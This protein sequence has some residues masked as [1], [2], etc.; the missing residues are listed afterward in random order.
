MYYLSSRLEC[1]AITN[2]RNCLISNELIDECFKCKRNYHLNE[3]GECVA[4]SVEITNANGSCIDH[5]FYFDSSVNMCVKH[6]LLNTFACE[7]FNPRE[8]GCLECSTGYYLESG[9]CLRIEY[10]HFT[11]GIHNWCYMSEYDYGYIDENGQ[12]KFMDVECHTNSIENRCLNCARYS[13]E[14]FF[15]GSLV[16]EDILNGCANIKKS[17]EIND[18]QEDQMVMKS[19][20]LCDLCQ[21]LHY[22]DE[23]KGICLPLLDIGCDISNG[24]SN[25]CTFCKRTHILNEKTGTCEVSIQEPI[26]FC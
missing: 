6:S 11:D 17:E 19:Q 5:L 15:N 13:M 18:K 20:Y 8:D 22:L 25:K 21:N 24:K 3:I 26:E 9:D 1:T 16:I 7:K 14:C 4:S 2:V 12:P 10:C 23:E